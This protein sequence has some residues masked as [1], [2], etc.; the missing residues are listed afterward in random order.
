M[1]KRSAQLFICALTAGIIATVSFTGIATIKGVG[2]T[3]TVEFTIEKNASSYEIFEPKQVYLTFEKYD[4]LNQVIQNLPKDCGYKKIHSKGYD[5][6]VLVVAGPL[7]YIDGKNTASDIHIYTKRHGEHVKCI[8]YLKPER[9]IRYKDGIIHTSY[10]GSYGQ[11]TTYLVTPDGQNVV[12]KDDIVMDTHYSDP[13][14]NGYTKKDAYSTKKPYNANSI[15]EIERLY[16][17]IENT[18]FIDFDIK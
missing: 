6:D 4:S 9:P 3:E 10:T 11:Y 15:E 2:T 13:I 14:C 1:K 16:K 17:K 5:G 8:G 12:I 18:P 7:Q